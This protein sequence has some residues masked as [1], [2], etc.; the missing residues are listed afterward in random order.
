MIHRT[1]TGIAI[2]V[3]LVAGGV[4][5]GAPDKDR[6]ALELRRT[7]QRELFV[8]QQQAPERLSVQATTP[9]VDGFAGTYPCKDI[10]LLAFMPLAEIGGGNGNDIWGWTDPLTGREYALMGRTSG[11]SFVDITDPVNPVYLGNL[12]PNG[13]NSSW[14]DIKVYANH[15]Y[16]VSE[17][18]GHGMQVFDLTQLRDVVSPPQ[19]FSAT[20]VYDDFGSAHN[21]AI[22]ESTGFAY[23]V[24]TGTCSGGPHFVDLSNPA[25]PVYA[26][27]HTETIYTHDTQCVTYAGPD[28]TYQ[29]REICFN[30]NENKVNV[31]DV[32]DK[33]NPVVLS[34]TTYTGT[35]YT[36]Q[37]WLTEDHRFFLFGDEL[38]EQNFGHNTRT[39]ILDVQDLDAPF[40]LATYD[41][42]T[43]A[44]DHNLYTLDGYAFQANYRAGLRIL[45]LADVENGNLSEVAFFDIYP[46][47]DAASF[48]GAWSVYPYFDSGV[49]VVS[50]IEQG[51]FILQPQ[52]GP[53]FRVQLDQATAS[54]CE[55]DGV[56]VGV[57]VVDRNGYVGDVTLDVTGLPAGVDASFDTN[58]VSAPGSALLD[59]SFNGAAPGTYGAAV[60]GDDGTLTDDASFVVEIADAMPVPTPQLSPADGAVEVT[61]T[62]TL[63]WMATTQAFEY[64]VQLATDPGFASVV[65]DETLATTTRT[66]GSELAPATPYY[67]RVRGSNACGAGDWSPTFTFTTLDIPP[68]LLVDDDDNGPDVRQEFVD[69]LN[70]LGVGF[71]VW[72]TGNTDNEP[73]AAFLTPYEAVIWFTGDEYGGAAGPGPNGESALAAWLDTSRCLLVTSQDYYYDRG[74]TSFMGEY[75]GLDSAT[76][77][78]LQLS[79]TGAGSVF[80]GLGTWILTFPY[81]N[82]T[83]TINPGAGAEVAFDSS[84]PIGIDRDGGV[85]RTAFWGFGVEALPN[86]TAREEALARFL[87]WCDALPA[88]DAD[89]DG[90]A[91][92]QDC[93]PGEAAVWSAPSPA[94]GL[95]LTVAPA[96]N[97]TWLPPTD[98]GGTTVTYDLLRS[99]GSADFD[100]AA[101]VTSGT[102][103][104]SATASLAPLSGEVFYYLVRAR[105]SCGG[106]LG[107]TSGGTPRGGTTCE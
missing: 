36:H 37:G 93:A 101:C 62:P 10:D 48:N 64:R 87:E 98:P 29:G 33:A 14:R 20:F 71:D 102:P 90:V 31:I 38:D 76:S 5:L 78:V 99:N 66:V 91:N 8:S 1:V 9:C 82:Y 15:A 103:A 17:A 30:S 21:V 50:G 47:S 6:D 16:I 107:Q 39:R 68:V 12:P 77:D 105:T 58:P 70:G 100:G 34:V 79:V 60:V 55:P 104:T 22:N 28:A 18:F 26:G 73:S 54:I 19:T 51:L 74:L 2:V 96:D 13:S 23:A 83:D 57:D 27:C 69:A 95:S 86:Q 63:T 61:R 72:D 56:T 40:V 85:Y 89:A 49:V 88:V 32:T 35:G 52:L 43:A 3:A 42:S 80:S 53:L 7:A 25:A 94:R 92:G 65:L 11:T 84:T 24:G 4:A 45:D 81:N 97:A 67:W 41:A 44:I 106:S 46:S 75:L 59:L